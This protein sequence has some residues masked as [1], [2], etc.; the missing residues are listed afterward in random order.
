MDYFFETDGR[1]AVF[2]CIVGNGSRFYHLWS[3]HGKPTVPV[4]IEEYTK[5]FVK[6]DKNFR[7]LTLD[8]IPDYVKTTIRKCLHWDL[9]VD[10]D[11]NKEYLRPELLSI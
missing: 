5:D 9:F 1:E 7:H 3:K 10:S 6:Y 8:E 4:I 11:G 2:I